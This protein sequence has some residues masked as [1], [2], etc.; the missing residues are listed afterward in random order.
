MFQMLQQMAVSALQQQIHQQFCFY[1]H[2]L[3]SLL[4][5]KN[6]SGDTAFQ[7]VTMELQ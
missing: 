1:Y 7:G 4:L 6:L 3:V 2:F 5:H